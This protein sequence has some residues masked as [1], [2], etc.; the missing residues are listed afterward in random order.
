MDATQS[1]FRIRI[2]IFHFRSADGDGKKRR[3]TEREGGTVFTIIIIIQI[4]Q[5]T[6]CGMH[7]RRTSVCVCVCAP[8]FTVFNRIV[9]GRESHLVM[10][11]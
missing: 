9:S 5:F 1:L 4:L 11:I 2:K 6:M 3:R 8:I 10:V 7:T